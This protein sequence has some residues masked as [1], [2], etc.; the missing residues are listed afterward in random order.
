MVIMRLFLIKFFFNITFFKCFKFLSASV[1][2]WLVAFFSG[3]VLSNT[4]ELSSARFTEKEL[5]GKQSDQLSCL[6][7]PSEYVSLSSSVSGIIANIQAERGDL[8]KKGQVLFSLNGDVERSSLDIFEARENFSKRKLDR[9]KSMFEDNMLSELARDELV[10]D[11]KLTQLAVKEAKEK[12]QRLTVVSPID[13][14][15]VSRSISVGEFINDQAA[16]DL[17]SIN[18]LHAEVVMLEK[19]YGIFSVGM[20][21][22]LDIFSRKGVQVEGE[23]VIV[24][25]V[26]DGASGTFGLRVE[27]PNPNNEIPAGLK[28]QIVIDSLT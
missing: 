8:I 19:H 18:P 14:L 25:R 22:K 11:H 20:K 4:Q 16:M 6:I 21:V 9:N 3:S 12:L 2:Y 27:I 15:V 5:Y 28:C 10:T 26:I 7:E 13:G 17:A 1:F 24:D 23:V